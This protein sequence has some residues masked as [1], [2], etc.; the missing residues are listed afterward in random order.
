MGLTPQELF[1][2]FNTIQSAEYAQAILNLVNPRTPEK[3]AAI[4]GMQNSHPYKALFVEE[5]EEEEAYSDMESEL[6]IVVNEELEHGPVDE[7]STAI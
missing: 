4:M 3:R 6:G 7:N 5:D 2:D 1:K